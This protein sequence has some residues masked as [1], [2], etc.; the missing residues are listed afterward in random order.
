MIRSTLIA[1]TLTTLLAAC[2][3]GT[4]APS[5]EVTPTPSNAPT[6]AP[7][8]SGAGEAGEG[9][10][11]PAGSPLKGGG[12]PP[13]GVSEQI[14]LSVGAGGGSACGG[15][16]DSADPLIH[17]PYKSYE[18]GQLIGTCVS[19]FAPGA[20]QVELWK[21]DGRVERFTL[22]AAYSS[23]AA[24]AAIA[25]AD[26]Q[27]WT[28]ADDP[29]GTYRVTASQG[30]LVAGAAFDVVAPSRPFIDVFTPRVAPGETVRLG[31]AG[32]PPGARVDL[33][34]YRDLNRTNADGVLLGDYVGTLP[35]VT[36]GPD[37][38]ALTSFPT[39]RDDPPG[40]YYLWSPALLSKRSGS[41]WGFQLTS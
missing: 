9:A 40:W 33:Y 7:S 21:P 11:Q 20:L 30:P 28:R 18:L 3:P 16:A 2:A 14:A 31:L 19:G 27:T 29:L 38:V 41:G 32:M 17:V 26:F 24:P 37:G 4:A 22:E 5:A 8:A 1:L 34:I 35:A 13:A 10:A 6:L 36:I 23:S 15:A 39:A 12:R 25:Q